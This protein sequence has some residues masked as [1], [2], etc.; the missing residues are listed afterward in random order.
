MHDKKEIEL[1][2]DELKYFKDRCSYLENPRNESFIVK[3]A[4]CK[5]CDSNLIICPSELEFTDYWWY[6][7]NKMCQYHHPGE[8][9]GREAFCSF[10]KQMK[11]NDR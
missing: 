2:Q 8:Q 7:S 6:C 10:A 1:L 4:V 5:S 11:K 3:F 9:T